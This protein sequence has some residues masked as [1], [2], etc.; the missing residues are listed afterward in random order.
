V[1][2]RLT[3]GPFNRVEGDLEVTLDVADGRVASAQVSSSLYRGFEHILLAK[4]PLDALVIVPRICGICS[5]SQSSAAATALAAAAGLEMPPNGRLASNLILACENLADH[6][7]HFYLFFMPDFA[8]EAYRGHCWH[9]QAEKRF[10][11]TV[12]EAQREA[13]PAR[14]D[15]L[16][17]MGYLAGKW[18][19]SLALQPGGTTRAVTATE[20]VRLLAVLREFRAF[21]STIVFGDA[22]EN[23]AAIS[24]VDQLAAW[25]QGR[26]ADF[27]RFLEIAGDLGLARVGRA[28]DGFLSYGAYSHGGEDGQPLFARGVWRGA[29]QPCDEALISEDV[30]HAW[31][32]G[33]RP[34]HPQQGETRPFTGEFS[35][36]ARRL[37]LVQGPALRRPGRRER[38]PGPPDGRRPAAAAGA[39]GDRRRQRAGA[40]RRPPARTRPRGAG[41]GA[42]GPRADTR[43][44]LLQAMASYPIRPAPCGLVEAARGALGHW[45]RIERG[46]IAGYQIIAPTTWN[47]SPRDAAGVPGALEQA[48]VGLPVG[49][50]ESAPLTRA[51]R[52][53]VV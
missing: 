34:L 23:V 28:S 20:K 6:L 14:A 52:R 33:D 39:G 46:R 21:L 15:L 25:A 2:R 32:H 51:A 29:W 50:G 8:R 37:H 17:L 48:L 36:S 12:G 40:G 1:S 26:P 11:A 18:P 3:I 22:L 31:L 49:E 45:L 44:S 7:T 38:C 42:L 13:L 10:K 16:R 24:S 53:A 4:H 9:D 30:S 5:V 19:H 41:D 47:F 35:R 43:R 27:P